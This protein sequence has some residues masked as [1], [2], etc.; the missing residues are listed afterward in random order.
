MDGEVLFIQETPKLKKVNLQ[1]DSMEISV[2]NDDVI[3]VDL[4]EMKNSNANMEKE[5]QKCLKFNPFG[6]ILEK[7]TDIDVESFKNQ[8]LNEVDRKFSSIVDKEN[9]NRSETIIKK[10]PK[11]KR[12]SGN[13]VARKRK[14]TKMVENNR[15]KNET[16]V[17]IRNRN[18]NL[19]IKWKNE[20]LNLKIC[21]RKRNRR[22][23]KRVLKQ[24]VLSPR[25][26][27]SEIITRP[28]SDVTLI[29]P[30]KIKTEKSPDNLKQTS[31]SSFFKLKC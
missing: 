28:S 11:R 16:E 30:K 26:D 12:P 1:N 4:V 5:K 18:I 17:S 23:K 6:E 13:S 7:N 20:E 25:L 9:E 21:K 27:S 3:N 29:K 31:I 8:Y 10:A 14:A 19:K 2:E 15:V 24:Y 22:R